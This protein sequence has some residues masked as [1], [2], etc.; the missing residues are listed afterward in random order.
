MHL[1]QIPEADTKFYIPSDLSECTP[2]QYINMCGL[3]FQFQTGQLEYEQF[4]LNALYKLC[5]FTESKKQLPPEDDLCKWSNI[6]KLSEYIDEFFEDQ[7][8]GTKVIKQYYINN[9]MPEISI[10][11]TYCGPADQFMNISFGEYADALRLFNDF[12][13]SGDRSLLYLIAAILYRPKKSFLFLRRRLNNF[14][15]DKR[16]KYNSKIIDS[17]AED[18]RHLHIGF[19]YGVYL[20]FASFQKFITTAKIQWGGREIDFS[21][22]FDSQDNEQPETVPGIG[23]DS[24]MFSIA[25]SGAFGTTEEVRKINFWEIMIRLYDLRKRDMDQKKREENDKPG[26]T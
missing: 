15:G 22:L 3:I 14:D 5:N 23:M 19:I 26:K 20:Y 10:W 24:I 21:I 16:V 11:R 25:E 6:Y 1:V 2:E 12:S 17:R 7:A 4:R 9:P 18:F 13:V 8:D